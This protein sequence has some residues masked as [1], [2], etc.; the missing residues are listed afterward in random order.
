MTKVL[1]A[2]LL[3]AALAACGARTPPERGAP[4]RPRLVVLLV[5][6]QLRPDLLV[7]YDSLYTG[8]LRRLN[9]LGLA[10]VNTTHDHGYTKTAPGH[11]ALST[12]VYPSRSGIV[13]NGWW[14]RRGAEWVEMENIG[15]VES[16]TLGA[17]DL[18][19]VS[20][21]NLLRPGFADWLIAASPRSRVAT[22]SAKDRGAVLLAGKSRGHVYWFAPE[23]GRFV[24]STYYT[25]AYPAWAESWHAEMMPRYRADTVWASTV[26]AAHAFRSRPDT[27]AH[28]GD[29]RNTSFPH[30]FAAERAERTEPAFWDWFE[31]TPRID[32]ATV[33]FARAM[34]RALSL[35]ADDAPDL[36]GV[37]LS[38][39]DRIGHDFGPLSREQLDNLLRL[40]RE[41]GELFS[42]LD[43]QVGRDRYIVALSADHG[44]ATTPEDA[45]A[46]GERNA[47]RMTDADRAALRA[48]IERS[49][50]RLDAAPDTAAATR[51][52]RELRTLPF[53]A[54]AWTHQELLRPQLADSFAVLFRNSYYP[55]RYV[56]EVSR[57]GVE[58]MYVPGFVDHDATGTDHGSPHWYDRLVP[59]VFMG[60]GIPAGRDTSRA[61]TADMAPTLARLLGIPHPADLDGRPR[62]LGAQP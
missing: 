17:P 1:L 15:D 62:S 22:V 45:I 12:G 39:T 32:A 28:E 14:E 5:V 9:D 50:A 11:A 48:A 57:L 53:V 29:G 3:S 59:F 8:G 42:F 19:G 24:T 40:D 7:R 27:A 20:P 6:D 16:P 60:P 23:K 18:P 38:A 31:N 56:E 37:S 25:S 52:A 30:R 2:V 35:G 13:A 26:P 41:L 34:V 46:L 54:N 44:V 33:D 10:L 51:L 36:L 49:G 43:R 4:A 61:S 58:A 21:R 47:H 55:N